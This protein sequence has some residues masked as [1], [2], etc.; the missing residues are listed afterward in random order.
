MFMDWKTQYCWDVSSPQTDL[1]SQCNLNQNP[2]M[3]FVEI[4]SW[5]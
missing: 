4:N 1:E 5:F 2:S 3:I